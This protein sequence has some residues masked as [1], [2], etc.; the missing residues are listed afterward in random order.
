MRKEDEKILEKKLYDGMI[1]N[2][3]EDMYEKMKDKVEALLEQNDE[4]L[5]TLDVRI[6]AE[7]YDDIF[8]LLNMI[9]VYPDIQSKIIALRPNEYK[10][11]VAI[12]KFFDKAGIDWIAPA[13][14]LLDNL[15]GQNYRR[16]FEDQKMIEYVN[17]LYDKYAGND[18][19][20]VS[21][22][23]IT[24]IENMVSLLTNG[25]MFNLKKFDDIGAIDRDTQY[26]KMLTKDIKDI[27]I[28]TLSNTDKLRNAIFM[29]KFGHTLEE[30]KRIYDRYLEDYDGIIKTI[31]SEG[32]DE[33]TQY[34]MEVMGISNPTELAYE[35]E[36]ISKENSLIKNYITFIKT[37][38]EESDTK[39]L[40]NHY[41]NAKV[42]HE[43]I[44]YRMDSYIRK[45]FCRE[46]NKV[47]Y[48]PK[49]EDKVVIDSKEV[50]LIQDDFKISMTSLDSYNEAWDLDVKKVKNHGMCT[51]LIANNNLN[52]APIRGA[53]LAFNNYDER[54]FY[55]SAP[56]DMG[57][58][59]FAND[60]NISRGRAKK[61]DGKV[62]IKFFLPNA[63]IDRTRRRSNEDIFER[64][65]LD[66][67]KIEETGKFKKQPAYVVY[68]S[69][70][71]LHS[72]LDNWDGKEML[73]PDKL[74]ECLNMDLFNDFAYRTKI[75][76]EYA[77]KDPKWSCDN[78]NKNDTLKEAERRGTKIVIVDRTH[79]MLKERLK[80]D[81]L[82]KQIMEYPIYEIN[83]SP[84]KRAEFLGMIKRL[85]VESENCRAGLNIRGD[86]NDGDKNGKLIHEE[87]REGL[88]SKQLMTM[89]LARIAGKLCLL[90]K[91][92]RNE[93]FYSI[94]DM[95]RDEVIK[96]DKS[97]FEIDPGYR[98]RKTMEN[99]AKV[100]ADIPLNAKF[101]AEDA[102]SQVDEETGKSGGQIVCEAIADV[103]ELDEYPATISEI[104]G[105]K[106]INNVILFSYLIAKGEKTLDAK[107]MDLLIQAAKF[108]DVGRDGKWNGLGEGKRHDYD[109]IPH[110]DPGALGAEF[111]MLKE[112]D[113]DGNQKYS[114]S[115]IAVVQTAISYHEVHEF[116]HNVFN[117]EVFDELCKRY[118]VAD[119]D[120]DKAKKICVYLKDADA[121]DR[122]RF[123]WST[124]QKERDTIPEHRKYER[125][126]WFDELDTSYLRTQTSFLIVDQARK[127]HMELMEKGCKVVYDEYGNL[128]PEALD[129]KG[130]YDAYAKAL[131][132]DIVDILEP[133]RSYL[134]DREAKYKEA[135]R[136]ENARKI[137]EFLISKKK[138]LADAEVKR[139]MD[140]IQK[141]TDYEK[142][143]QDR[144][145]GRTTTITKDLGSIDSMKANVV[146]R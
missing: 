120:R 91:E 45:F 110:A 59:R 122:T 130:K 21:L 116:R 92:N 15:M 87:L 36:R 123:M 23:E 79:T 6:L 126:N 134:S 99:F 72:Y 108:H 95:V 16:L 49:E 109:D 12:I 97:W 101:S 132:T 30:A 128:R 58:S 13:E 11:F 115:D 62:D 103:R 82:N 111:Y 96:Y 73:T 143:A 112:H 41:K 63:Q 136:E 145:I 48:R 131:N 52:H 10:I 1:R 54:S 137:E 2:I 5:D 50:Y 124:D 51:N 77:K 33:I 90:E 113:K 60:M 18:V 20:E 64:R 125:K 121:V 4:V 70:E 66:P 34:V 106:H 114:K 84:E 83:R 144:K 61:E 17:Q 94:I 93:C 138:E 32:K 146:S 7:D 55:A 40:A 65:E 119:E 47:L 76:E 78:Q 9:A 117:E 39:K 135:S 74:K 14:D 105:Q 67:K 80:I 141:N 133:Y 43:N 100:A 89:R 88:F 22:T 140:V 25:N 44:V 3:P 81:E 118:G 102:L 46:K 75:V 29:K 129:N 28:E 68:F 98:M 127:I 24:G 27:Y 86:E 104:H 69:E 35:V 142:L 38:L 139:L 26:Q 53:C 8:V 42:I 71:S 56:W 19:D 57:S 107:G 85:I 37:I 31:D